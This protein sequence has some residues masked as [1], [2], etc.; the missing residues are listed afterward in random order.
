MFKQVLVIGALITAGTA[1]CEEKKSTSSSSLEKAAGDVSSAFNDAARSVGDS[2]SKAVDSAKQQATAALDKASA[3]ARD[4]AVTE[5]QGWID[6]AKKQVQELTAKASAA[7]PALKAEVE[8]LVATLKTRFAE[9]ETAF[10]ELVQ[11]PAWKEQVAQLKVKLAELGTT[12][13]NLA[14]KLK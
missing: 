6:A 5:A 10:N 12:A 4:V 11:S 13:S 1:G 9:A 2:A 7:A 8:P 3:Q 14:S